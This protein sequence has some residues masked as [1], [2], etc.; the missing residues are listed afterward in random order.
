MLEKIRQIA[1][2]AGDEILRFY[3]Q[4]H[5]V[6]YKADNSPLTLADQA[7]HNLIAAALRELTPEIPVLS[8]ES[9]VPAYEERRNW[10][11]FWIVDPLDGTKEFIKQTGEFTLNIALVSGN[12]LELGVVYVP[13]QRLSYLAEK[14]TGAFKQTKDRKSTRLNSS[15]V[16]ISYAVF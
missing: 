2:R 12:S 8:E 9:A 4:D 13:A 10:N 5:P 16:A 14:E 3:G 7:A 11:R 15:H 1:I 6:D